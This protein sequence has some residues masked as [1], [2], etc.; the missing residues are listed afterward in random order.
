[1]CTRYAVLATV[2]VLSTAILA[3]AVEAPKVA[4]PLPALQQ[5]TEVLSPNLTR[6]DTFTLSSAKNYIADYPAM[7]AD[8][9]VNAVIEIPS[10][11]SAK[12]EVKSDGQFHWDFEDG[13]PRVVKYL[14]YPGNYGMIPQT[15]SG[16]GDPLDILVLGAAVPRGSVVPVRPIG[17]CHYTEKGERDD[18]ILAV[19]ADTPLSDVASIADLD[20]R[21]PGA[22]QIIQLWFSNYKGPGK[23]LFERFDGPTEAQALID[24]N[25]RAFG[26]SN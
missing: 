21:Y 16:D 7:N 3:L 1:M 4:N 23:M 26:G 13:N 15:R 12:W 22:T 19:M 10:G 17:V 24:A 20:A 18:K 9:T 11:S 8:G 5:A 2:A 14:S 6:T 25:R